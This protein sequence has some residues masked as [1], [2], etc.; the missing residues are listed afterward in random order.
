MKFIKSK[1]Y[2]F[3]RKNFSWTGKKAIEVNI[4]KNLAS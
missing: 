2:I 3:R 1:T 4:G